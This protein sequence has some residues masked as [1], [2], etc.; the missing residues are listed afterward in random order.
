MRLAG[1]EP[2]EPYPGRQTPWRCRC[3]TCGSVITPRL[4]NALK[5]GRGPC[6]HCGRIKQADAHRKV[7]QDVRDALRVGGVEPMEPYPGRLDRPWRSVCLRCG[8]TVT[9]RP[10]VVIHRGSDP[11]IYCSGGLLAEED[12]VQTM[13][14]AGLEPIDSFPG[15]RPPWRCRC[16]RCGREVTPRLYSIKKGN[17]G[18]KFCAGVGPLSEEIAVARFR[19]AGIEALEP[20]PG[21]PNFRWRGRCMRCG[22]EVNASLSTAERP[23]GGNGCAECA[24]K[25][26]AEGQRIPQQIAEEYMIAAGA[27]PLEPYVDGGTP[28]RCRCLHCGDEVEPRL[29]LI[30]QGVGPC[31]RCSVWGFKRTSPALVYLVTHPELKAHKIGVAGIQ[32]SRLYK[33]RKNGWRVV[34]TLEVEKGSSALFIEKSVISWF[35]TS[36]WPPAGRGYDGWTETV[37]E[38]AVTLRTIWRHVLAA[39]VQLQES[40]ALSRSSSR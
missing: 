27:V 11:C 17:G 32:T 19:S 38:D 23:K 16:V 1:A 8:R 12:A 30:R 7:E 24:S 39:S 2:L 28:W 37:S 33:H 4:G 15:A 40:V 29:W 18:C 31:P 20:Y 13:R 26:R 9:P 6:V 25:G 36:G 35:R 14:E 22:S 10:A 21:K 34:R 3:N 5:E